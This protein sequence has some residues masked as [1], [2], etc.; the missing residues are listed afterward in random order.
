[1][2]TPISRK[3]NRHATV[4]AAVAILRPVRLVVPDA[5]S[6]DLRQTV[7]TIAMATQISSRGTKSRMMNVTKLCKDE[8]PP[9]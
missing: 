1:M 3:S 9:R 8:C 5:R 7:I 4:I 2:L 6:R